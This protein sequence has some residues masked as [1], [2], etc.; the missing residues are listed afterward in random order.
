MVEFTKLIKLITKH[1]ERAMQNG[2][3]MQKHIR[4]SETLK[5]RIV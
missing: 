3:N 1:T 2:N 4:E 5:A